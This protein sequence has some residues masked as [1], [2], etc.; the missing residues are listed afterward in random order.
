MLSHPLLP[1][2][3]IHQR[4]SITPS[5][6]VGIVAF[7]AFRSTIGWCIELALGFLRVQQKS[8]V[9]LSQRM[10]DF[11]ADGVLAHLTESTFGKLV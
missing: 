5:H 10:T 6:D 11:V 7:V 2:D 9:R 4:Q 1:R 8:D 3:G